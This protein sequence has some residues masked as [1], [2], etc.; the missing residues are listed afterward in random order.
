MNAIGQSPQVRGCKFID[1]QYYLYIINK[2]AKRCKTKFERLKYIV[3]ISD[4][5]NTPTSDCLYVISVMNN[6]EL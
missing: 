4:I 6:D 5:A 3:N 2:P 1:C